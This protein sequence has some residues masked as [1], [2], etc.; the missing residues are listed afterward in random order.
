MQVV[1]FK[2]LDEQFAV[3][4]EKIKSINDMMEVTAVPKAPAYIK[5][6]INLRGNVSSLLDVNLLL[7]L[8]ESKEQSSIIILN[9]QE[10]SVGISVDEVSEV[11]DIEESLIEKTEELKEKPYLKGVINFKDRIVTLIDINKMIPNY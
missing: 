11:L 3:E 1:I 6:L 5:G 4:T 7:G 10:E 9:L 8:E 2:I